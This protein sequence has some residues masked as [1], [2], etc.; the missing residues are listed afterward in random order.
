MPQKHERV[1][2]EVWDKDP[3][4]QEKMGVVRFAY[5]DLANLG[6]S[7]LNEKHWF[8]LEQAKSGEI[9]LGFQAKLPEVAKVSN[10]RCFFIFRLQ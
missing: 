3:F 5:D 6:A 10:T 8:D 4:T 2:V 1:S 9:Q 7:G